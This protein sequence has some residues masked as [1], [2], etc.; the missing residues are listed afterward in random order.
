MD[1]DRINAI[2]A[3]I[4]AGMKSFGKNREWDFTAAVRTVDT[5]TGTEPAPADKW[6]MVD[7]LLESFN[8]SNSGETDGF[9]ARHSGNINQLR[10]PAAS[11]GT[12]GFIAC[13]S[14]NIN[15]LREPAPE[16]Q[17]AKT[18]PD[19]KASVTDDFIACHSI[20]PVPGPA[21][22]GL[23]KI[24]GKRSKE[25]ERILSGKEED[26]CPVSNSKKDSVTGQT[27]FFSSGRSSGGLGEAA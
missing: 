6:A 10:E 23:E 16:C 7:R 5:D 18:V 24:R 27:S 13:H 9:N 17:A 2:C 1:I 12:D 22:N 11:G 26:V 8:A 21:G 3:E 25:E 4:N 15:Q 19:E 14:G 20:K